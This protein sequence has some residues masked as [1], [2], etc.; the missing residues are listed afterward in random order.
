MIYIIITKFDIGSPFFH[1]ITL[2][3]RITLAAPGCVDAI[4]F[5]WSIEMFLLCDF[6]FIIL[7]AEIEARKAG[8]YV[9]SDAPLDVWGKRFGKTWERVTHAFGIR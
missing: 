7:Q 2:A 8:E 6:T 3:T 4:S 5:G 1:I 9:Q